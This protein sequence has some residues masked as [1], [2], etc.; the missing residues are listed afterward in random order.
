MTNWLREREQLSQENIKFNDQFYRQRLRAL[1]SS[2]KLIEGLFKK[3]EE[4]DLL[5][6]TYVFF[7]TD[8]GYHIS[9]HR[10][11]PGKEC[12]FEEDIN[13]QVAIRGPGVPDRRARSARS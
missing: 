12:S 2:D 9:Q 13:I 7:T 1:P 10:L 4:Y 8:N 6:N 5:D 11:Q 3:L